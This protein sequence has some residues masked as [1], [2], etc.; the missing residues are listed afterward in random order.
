MT[1]DVYYDYWSSGSTENDPVLIPGYTIGVAVEEPG[2]P[3][4]PSDQVTTMPYFDPNLGVTDPGPVEAPPSRP[5]P[6]WLWLV[7]GFVVYQLLSDSGK[8]RK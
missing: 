5:V 7:G 6:W 8:G 1:P 4:E 3:L 2:G